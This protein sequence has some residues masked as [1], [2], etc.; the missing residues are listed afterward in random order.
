[1]YSTSKITLLLFGASKKKA[2]FTTKKWRNLT[3][4][5]LSMGIENKPVRS[6]LIFL[7]IFLSVYKETNALKL[8]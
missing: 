2:L 1:M 3:Q 5:N 8:Q 4:G 6:F 7:H